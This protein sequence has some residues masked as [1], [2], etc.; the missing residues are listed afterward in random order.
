M[1]Y[2]CNIHK[3]A[4]LSIQITREIFQKYKALGGDTIKICREY[5]Y[6]YFGFF[7]TKVT[8][9]HNKQ[10][11]FTYLVCMFPASDHDGIAHTC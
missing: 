11:I 7:F 3:Y 10:K 8:S 2:V 5:H 1:D 6:K 4:Y 9:R